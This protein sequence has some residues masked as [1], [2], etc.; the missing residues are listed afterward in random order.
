MRENNYSYDQLFYHAANHY[1]SL[2]LSLLFVFYQEQFF[3][4]R[5]VN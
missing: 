1:A 5:P 2:P 4:T 3:I